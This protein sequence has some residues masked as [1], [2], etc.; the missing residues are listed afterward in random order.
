MSKHNHPPTYTQSEAELEPPGYG[1]TLPAS[2]RIGTTDTAPVVSVEEVQAHLKILGA[3]G[4]LK[5]RVT[6]AQETVSKD[7]LEPEA[8]WTVFLCRAVHRFEKWIQSRPTGGRWPGP[9][10]IIP[11]DVLMVWHSFMLVGAFS[12]HFGRSVLLTSYQNPLS[13]E[14]DGLRTLPQL[15]HL[16]YVNS[17]YQCLPRLLTDLQHVSS[18]GGRRSSQLR[19]TR[20][21]ANRRSTPGI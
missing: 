13:Y 2:F 5:T 11:L 8:A 12:L 19:H 4:R 10:V 9:W 21:R 1:T 20:F 17:P 16:E 3:F 6:L 14:G 15:Q 7:R 18:T